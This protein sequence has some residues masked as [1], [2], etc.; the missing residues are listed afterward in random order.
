MTHIVCSNAEDTKFPP[1]TLALVNSRHPIC[2]I[3]LFYFLNADCSSWHCFHNSLW[4]IACGSENHCSRLIFPNL[5]EPAYKSPGSLL[6]AD[7][8]SLGL[9]WDLRLCISTKL[10]GDTMLLVLRPWS[11]RTQ[12]TTSWTA[13][14]SAKTLGIDPFSKFLSFNHSSLFPLFPQLLGCFLQLPPL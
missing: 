5:N 10:P 1:E 13:P 12:T 8:S 14:I 7:S 3:L 4:V 2:S 6:N 9:P 11:K